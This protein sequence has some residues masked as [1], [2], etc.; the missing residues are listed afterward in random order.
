LVW[1]TAGLVEVI[2]RPDRP[3]DPMAPTVLLVEDGVEER[4]ALRELLQEEGIQVVG[5]AGNGQEGVELAERVEPDVVLMDLRMPVMD[6]IEATRQI[7]ERLPRTQ[8]LIL[9]VYD[10]ASLDRSAAEVGA[11]AYLVKGCSIQFIRDMII[12]AAKFKTSAEL[13]ARLRAAD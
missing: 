3:S 1:T 12:Q 10:D 6:G 4:E 13:T 8:V 9:T 2:E 11:Y 5:G 7:V